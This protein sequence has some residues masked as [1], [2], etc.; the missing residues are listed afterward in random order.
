MAVFLF[1]M[2]KGEGLV[3]ADAEGGRS[4]GWFRRGSM[5]HVASGESADMSAHSKES[6]REVS[7]WLDIRAEAGGNKDF[8]IQD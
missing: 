8:R 2:R 3:A 1:Y 6:L 7:G 5:R 4:A